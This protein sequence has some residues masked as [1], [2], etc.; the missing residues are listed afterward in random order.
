LAGLWWRSQR[1][2]Q[3]VAAERALLAVDRQLG[4]ADRLTSAAEFLRRPLAGGFEAAAIEDAAQRLASAEASHLP[5]MP[6]SIEG[7]GRALVWLIA[8]GTLLVLAAQLGLWT[9]DALD[10]TRE[11][12]QAPRPGA[13]L[14]S[15]EAVA[16]LDPEA[17]PSPDPTRAPA[18]SKRPSGNA[19]AA[20]PSKPSPDLSDQVKESQGKSGVGQSAGAQST[21]AASQSRSAPSSQGQSSEPEKAAAKKDDKKP[22]PVAEPT[23]DPEKKE[24]QEEDSGSTAGKGSSKGS[25]K[26]PTTSSWKSKDQVTNEDDQQIEDDEQA[27]DDEEEQE[28]RGGVQP[29]MRDR[30]PPVSRDLQIAFGNRSNPDANGRGGPSEQKK[31]RGVA[32]LVLGVPIPDRVKGQPGPGPT[33]VTQERVEPQAEAPEARPASARAPRSGPMGSLGHPELD[34]WTRAVVRAYFLARRTTPQQP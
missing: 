19:V 32:S 22:R 21:S 2:A 29:H 9:R 12:A 15:E 30:R 5:A 28:S 27:E 8:G 11:S 16:K 24:N 31:S 23:E 33:K 20:K 14:A 6:V 17:S 26:N 25:N 3:P 13:T 7:K 18:D 10:S 4:T 1:R 34:P